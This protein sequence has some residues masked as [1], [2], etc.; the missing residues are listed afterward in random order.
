VTQAPS[1]ALSNGSALTARESDLL[2]RA[3]ERVFSLSRQLAAA[4]AHNR[5]LQAELDHTR[6]ML[7]E[8]RQG[9]E[10]LSAQVSSLQRE[11]EREFQERSEL[12][13]LLASLQMQMQALLPSMVTPAVSAPALGLRAAPQRASTPTLPPGDADSRRGWLNRAAREIRGLSRR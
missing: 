1:S 12:R 8:T 6:E 5:R 11:V 3:G 9:R 2:R 4:E 7:A 10:I 13:K